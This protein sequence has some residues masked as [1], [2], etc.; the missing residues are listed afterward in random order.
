MEKWNAV[1]PNSQ[2]AIQLVGPGQLKLNK[3]KPVMVPGPRQVLAKVEAVGL[4]FSDLKLL[5][6]FMDHPR[7][8]EIVS[9]LPQDVLKEIP[10]Y[11]PGGKA[12]VPGHEVTCRIVAVGTEV[13]HH[14]VG[15]RVLVQTDYRDLRTPQS[16][17]AFGY[18]FEGALQE[19]VLMDE[20][21]IMDKSTGKRFLIPAPERLSASAIALV[22]PWACVENAYV[23][24]QRQHI[25]PGGKLLVVAE[26][27]HAIEGL[28]E[29]LAGYKPGT[30]TAVCAEG[31]QRQAVAALGL[32]QSEVPSLAAL[33]DESLDDI[34]YFGA[35]KPALEVLNDK[36][37]PHA[38]IN[39]I[40][41]GRQI[42]Q[43][44]SVG[45][46]RV[47]YGPTRWT[48]T[49]GTSAAEAYKRIPASPEI[50][51]GDKIVVIGAGGPMGQMHVIRCLCQGVPRVSVTGTDVDDARLE[52]LKQKAA[53]P[54]QAHH[55]PLRLSNTQ[56]AP[57]NEKFTYFALMAPVGA[58]V[59]AAIRDS[60]AGAIINIFAGIPAPTRQD[61]DL[62]M[63]LAKGCFMFGS[64]GSEIRD[65][66]IVLRKVEAG[67]LDTDCSVD[68]IAGMAGAAAGIEAVE[69]RTLAG[70][71]IVYP[72]L[73]ELGLVPLTQL[74][75]QL[76][77]VA[78]R[79]RNGMWC[80][81]AEEALLEPRINADKRA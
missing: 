60:A 2:H 50:R 28:K 13:Q 25:K 45:V 70:K 6:Q 4:C 44:V 80:K 74:K 26:T 1:I 41:G 24:I 55:V 56:K 51:P 34:L 67:Q 8:K 15:E 23:N 29:A 31:S 75:S 49:T 54:A 46:G 18:N 39:I 43:P 11:V 10:S 14:K 47:H 53:G 72:M 65:M 64:S 62:D 40:T 12:T 32:R 63:Y 33:P 69:K 66:E 37:G 22:E 35:S 42:G 21:V 59:A 16:N 27:G 7:K 81:E 19:Y 52:S 3:E 5:K 9:G 48:G 36:L 77:A 71:I 76:P 68:A 30:I 38:I 58:L 57:L 73:H 61:L 17:A 20:R 79:L 78:A